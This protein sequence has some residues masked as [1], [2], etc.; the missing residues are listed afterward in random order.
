MGTLQVIR[1]RRRRHRRRRRAA[2]YYCDPAEIGVT[3]STATDESW[4]EPMQRATISHHLLRR[5]ARAKKR[6]LD[7]V[8]TPRTSY[9]VEKTERG[10]WRWRV[11]RLIDDR[12]V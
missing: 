1:R 5:R 11:I 2:A 7:H 8:A 12:Y 6:E 9:R 4:G 3:T 10:P